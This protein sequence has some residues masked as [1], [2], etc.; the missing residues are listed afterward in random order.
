MHVSCTS[1]VV[2][3]T[4]AALYAPVVRNLPL[5]E[6]HSLRF[7]G[8]RCAALALRR[9]EQSSSSTSLRST[10]VLVCVIRKMPS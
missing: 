1:H 4:V 7:F 5:P 8:L 6:P 9:D 2:P 10:S 3:R